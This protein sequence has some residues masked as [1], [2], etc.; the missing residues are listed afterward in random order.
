MTKKPLGRGLNALLSIPSPLVDN[1]EVLS[2]DIE[3]IRPGPQQP[4]TTFDEEKLSELA[5]SIKASGIIQPL[6][7]RRHGGLYELIAGERRWR[8]AQLANLRQ[9]PV[10][11]RRV[12]DDRVLEF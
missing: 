5:Q 8:A 2:V 9:V 11:V 7:V 3:S 12:P 1:D 6:L 4:R 10:I